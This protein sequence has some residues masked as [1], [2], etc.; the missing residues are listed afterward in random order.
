MKRIRII[1]LPMAENTLRVLHELSCSIK[2]IKRVEVLRTFYLFFAT[3]LKPNM[4]IVFLWNMGEQY[5][6]MSGAAFITV[7]SASVLFAYRISY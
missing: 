3:N 7:W 6:L 4:P 2:F 1:I 5:I